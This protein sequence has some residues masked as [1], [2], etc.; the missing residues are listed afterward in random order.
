MRYSFK[1][2]LTFVA[3]GLLACGQNSKSTGD[4]VI[5]DLNV[6]DSLTIKRHQDI[7]HTIVHKPIK[8]TGS[9]TKKIID[10]WNSST[11]TGLCKFFPVFEMTVYLNDK[12]T[13]NFRI[14]AQSIKEDKDWCYDLGEPDFIEKLLMSTE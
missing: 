3:I 8:L 2:I 7:N 12:K 10:K 14:N 4:K 1:I 6:V 13:R 11:G 5:L 9:Q